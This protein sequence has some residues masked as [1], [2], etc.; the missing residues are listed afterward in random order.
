MQP[1]DIVSH[2]R[3]IALLGAGGMGEVYRAEDLRLQRPV[4]LK[5]L[6]AALTG[7]EEAKGRLLVEA[8]AVSALDHP[9]ICTLHEIDET[10]DGRLFL[11]MACYEGETLKAR[12]ARG[13]LTIDDAIEIVLQVARGVAAA[14]EA[15]I[16]HRDIKPG[17]VFL[18]A[19]T[20]GRRADAPPAAQGS[21]A[22]TGDSARVKLL[23]FG[24][25]KLSR[26]LGLTR[27]GT[28]VG[29][30]AYM[31]PERVAGRPADARTDVWSLGVVLYEMLAGRLP[32][33]GENDVALLRAIV[34]DTPAP[35][36]DVRPDVPPDL[37]AVVGRALA[38]D[39]A[40]RYASA[41][42]VVLALDAV[43]AARTA[44]AAR[45][46]ETPGRRRGGR[47][48]ALVGVGVLAAGATAAWLAVRAGRERA[49]ERAVGEMTRLVETENYEAAFRR[50]HTLP[51]SQARHPAVERARRELFL[52]LRVDTEPPGARV[53]IK[54]YA[55][56]LAPW[57]ALGSS[58]VETEGTIGAFRWRIARPG[59]ETFEGTGLAQ[60]PMGEITFA[61]TADGTTPPGMV[62]VRGGEVAGVGRLPDFFIDRHELTNK[63]FKA[64]VDAGAYSDVKYW[65][66][67]FVR[68]GRELSW[69]EAIAGFTDATGRPGPS[70]WELGTYPEGQDDWPVGG[71]SWY[72]AAAY[73][74]F[75]GKALPTVHHW[76]LAAAVGIHSAILEWSNFS[77]RGAA[78]V[79]Q[80]QG[81]GPFGTYDM[82]GNVKE[83]CANASGPRRYIL[84]GAWN[85]PNYQY[86]QP[87]ARLPFDRSSNNGV[88]LMIAPGPD[89]VPAAAV[90]PVERFARDYARERPVGDDV[91]NA[92]A[93]LYSY[94]A[95]DLRPSVD[96][97]DE[98]TE[99]WRVE[100]VSYDAAYG[101]ERIKAYLFLPKNASPPYQTVVY[102]P[103]AGGFA[104][105][106]FQQAEMA[107][108]GFLVKAGRALLF[109]MCKGTYE[110]RLPAPPAGP[111]ALRDLTI[112]QVK[113]VRRSVDYLLT[114]PDVAHDRLAYFGVSLGANVAP[115]VLSVERR[116]TTA[117][118]WS[119]GLPSAVRPAEV[120]P[121]NFAPRVTLPI[122]MLNGRDD[123][124]FPPATSQEPMFRLFGTPPGEKRRA[125]YEGG[126]V[127]PFSRL[128]KDT[129]DWLDR[130]LG[131][132]A[133][134]TRNS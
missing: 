88:R 131:A 108:L 18:C 82:A 40:A 85:E 60:N 14:H 46:S 39:P 52:P 25:A 127:F 17:N 1:G 53:E 33:D 65:Q 77:G 13:P 4:A 6:P 16:I 27:T 124:T 79:G 31:A 132:P 115:M 61:L 94:D 130:Y 54:G 122:L 103:H 19:Q 112:Q 7:N 28:T 29:T 105:R 12:L 69:S 10:A 51:A 70:T 45:S 91:F 118:L 92:L 24:I 66:E 78:R 59:F 48:A 123:F 49:V 111:S 114:R 73:A 67:P 9:N 21:A 43:A 50:L 38:K 68:D 98:G 35:V 55:E 102:F 107:Y 26:D 84:G 76:R 110:R 42:E 74:R 117:V 90:G 23:D 104:L 57:I 36:R 58:P 83:W 100:R 126:H 129:L 93:S 62:R 106:S 47:A 75:A 3:V 63:A 32:F 99:H 81:L 5:F 2:Y 116:F 128:I 97:I 134:R 15:G 80:Y 109:P 64:F 56:P 89:G 41:S 30:L 95:A 71:I 113:D 37:A 120:D 8:R 125:V 96:A 101:G 22:R 121:I 119:G 133:P 34:D 20:G 44:A 11:A 72:E 87:D 86:Q